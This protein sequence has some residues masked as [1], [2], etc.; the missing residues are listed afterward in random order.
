MSALVISIKDDELVFRKRLNV[1]LIN[2]LNDIQNEHRIKVK[3]FI[4]KIN[5]SNSL[6]SDDFKK[7]WIECIEND[8]N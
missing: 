2:C 6:Y 8:I 5:L 1:E 7:T 4:E 3:I